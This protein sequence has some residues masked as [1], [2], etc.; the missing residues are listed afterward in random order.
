MSHLNL[1][2]HYMQLCLWTDVESPPTRF[3]KICKLGVLTKGLIS[4]IYKI[5]IQTL[6]L[7]LGISMTKWDSY[8]NNM[9]P[10]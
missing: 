7:L 6:T 5:L 8:L 1:T 4:D 9:I 2:C 3:E 10:I